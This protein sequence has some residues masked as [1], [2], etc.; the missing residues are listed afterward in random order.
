MDFR[1]LYNR[2][3]S[4]LRDPAKAWEVVHAENRPLNFVWLNFT[5]PLIL[6]VS[7]S[8]FLGSWIFTNTTLNIG[9]S[10]L[11]GIK[12]FVLLLILSWF[13]AFIFSEII[14]ALDM[15]NNFPVSF[16]IITYSLSPL[17]LCLIIS[18]LFES[19]IFVNILSFYG[20]YIFLT[21]VEKFLKPPENKKIYLL[22]AAFVLVAGIYIITGKLLTFLIDKVYFAFFA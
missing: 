22:G 1:F 13:S 7:I 15:G 8:A 17:F 16:R 14:K 21:G 18:L 2:L 19:L 20:I 12:Y 9:Y 10:I 4:V 11:A 6:M 3:S 5:F